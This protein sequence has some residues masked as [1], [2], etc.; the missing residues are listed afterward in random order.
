MRSRS[1]AAAAAL[2][3]LVL[4]LA[5]CAETPRPVAGPAGTGAADYRGLNGWLDDRQAEALPAL[6]HS[7]RW[8]ARLPPG[9]AVGFGD[10]HATAAEWQT[11]CAQL[12]SVPEGDSAAMRRFL[13]QHLVPV[14]IGND[15]GGIGMFTGYYAPELRGDWRQ[16]EQ[17]SVP[18]YRRP[19]LR[20]NRRMPD[21]AQIARG[22]L[23]GRGLELVWVD[24]AIDAFFLEIQG[25]GRIRL[26]DGGTVGIAYA[27]QNG[28]RY[29]AIGR[30]LIDRGI[31]TREEMSMTLI[32]DWLRNN[33]DQAQELMELNPSYVFF[34]IVD[35]DEV[36]GAMAEP[37]TPG[38]SLAVDLNHIPLGVP[39][40]LDIQH[41][42]VPGGTLRRL[43]MAQ[44]TGGAIR[45]E[46]AGDVY[47]GT[48]DQAAHLAGPMQATGRY[49]MLVPR[50]ALA[51][52]GGSGR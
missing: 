28:H 32:R 42:T 34:R 33:P 2:V 46:V 19:T 38:R 13:E 39:L 30:A 21:R 10:I 35:N 40:W 29:F 9:Q 6:R 52:R 20:G 50:S 8:F 24:D 17:F 45:G 48:G 4:W 14:P 31:A 7:C 37:L 22:A 12:A 27:G 5:G 51:R 44:D 25:S 3:A 18:L 26:P 1:L 49:F 15:E 47:W 11:V 23:A 36:R 16:S 41:P 43:V